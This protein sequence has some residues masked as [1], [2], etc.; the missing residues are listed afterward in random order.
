VPAHATR[1]PRSY[2]PAAARRSHLLEVA[3]GLV[4]RGGWSALSMQGLAIAACVSR[5]L[6]YERFGS[7]DEL[8][9]ATLTHLFERAYDRAAAIAATGRD[10]QHT[11]RAAFEQLLNL[12]AEE[13]QAL[14]SLA[15][16]TIGMRSGL[17]RA[18]TRLRNRIASIW[19]PYVAQ[20]TGAGPAEATALAWMSI[21]ASWALIDLVADG[22][23]PRRRAADLYVRF[24]TDTLG[25]KR[26]SR[27]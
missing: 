6:V 3:G 22:T 9:L 8:A 17:A 20:Q 4:R 26:R 10:L 14:R 15:G 16:G 19:V 13:L 5:Q 27:T 2:L 1:V 23:L 21:T 11:V 24:V 25:A 7:A 12:P 18:R